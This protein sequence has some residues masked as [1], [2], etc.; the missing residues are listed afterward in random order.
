MS[1]SHRIV[2]RLM[3]ILMMFFLVM[4]ILTCPK[5]AAQERTL[6]E[7]TWIKVSPGDT[8]FSIARRHGVG[9]A[10]LQ[11]WNNLTDASIRAGMRLRVRPPTASTDAFPEEVSSVSSLGGGLAA[12][13]VGAG[14]T[15]YS[16]ANRY[17]LAP[18]SLMALNPDLHGALHEGMRI[19]VPEDRIIRSRVVNRGETLFGIAK[20]EGVSVEALRRANGLSTSTISVGQ[21][22][23]IPSLVV[24]DQ[25]VVRLPAAGVFSILPFPALL[26]GRPL[27]RD[28][29]LEKNSFFIAHPTLPVGTVVVI[30]TGQRHIFAEVAEHSPSSRPL[31]IEGS[32]ALFDALSL[33][34]GDRVTL[35]KVH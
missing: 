9:V 24:D 32:N 26:E 5:A 10:D 35:W 12:V 25:A 22:L 19:I 28:R 29:V 30:S 18:D 20:E 16:L 7:D 4:P 34:P 8:L 15:L 1:A 33:I 31:F 23:R 14:Q 11:Q 6:A 21:R 13:D 2:G 27:S 3:G 17:A